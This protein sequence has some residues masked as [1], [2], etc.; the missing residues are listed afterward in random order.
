MDRPAAV[1]R[2]FYPSAHHN[3]I[4]TTCRGANNRLARVISTDHSHLAGA[5]A[6]CLEPQPPAWRHSQLLGATTSCLGPLGKV[7]G[8]DTV[9][10]TR[11]QSS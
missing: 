11:Q 7:P 1:T 3:P 10:A 4:I 2:P 6:T 5:T 8:R 9:V